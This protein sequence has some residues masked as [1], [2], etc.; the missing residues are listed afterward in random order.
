[1]DRDKKLTGRFSILLIIFIAKGGQGNWEYDND[2]FHISVSGNGNVPKY[3][4]YSKSDSSN[5]YQLRFQQV[6]NA[7]CLFCR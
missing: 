7:T 1:M 3:T 2:D 6:S 4:F 5:K